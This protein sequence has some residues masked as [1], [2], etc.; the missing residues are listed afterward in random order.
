MVKTL[1]L[2]DVVTETVG[3]AVSDVHGVET[4]AAGWKR[5]FRFF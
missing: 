5:R 3:A 1:P 4:G 2:R